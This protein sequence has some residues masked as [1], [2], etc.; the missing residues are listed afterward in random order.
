MKSEVSIIEKRYLSKLVERI[1]ALR[2]ERGLSQE[3]LAIQSEIARSLMRGYERKE[4][5][6]S[7]GNLIRIIHFGLEM[8]VEEFFSEGFDFEKKKKKSSRD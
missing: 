8:K 1:I 5:N 6:I 2:K 7:Y 3:R 4:R